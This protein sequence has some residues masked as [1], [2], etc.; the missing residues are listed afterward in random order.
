MQ[1]KPQE[2]G[3]E[4]SIPWSGANVDQYYPY[5]VISEASRRSLPDLEEA[6]TP[7]KWTT[8]GFLVVDHGN[9]VPMIFH[10]VIA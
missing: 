7:L 8:E 5:F 1:Q 10:S 2:G 4:F 6:W 3:V 9:A